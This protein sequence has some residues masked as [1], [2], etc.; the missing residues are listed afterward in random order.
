[1]NYCDFYV[2]NF[3][4]QLAIP[5]AVAFFHGDKHKRLDDK[6]IKNLL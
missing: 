4:Y 6:Q 3:I 5:V 1:M 2:N